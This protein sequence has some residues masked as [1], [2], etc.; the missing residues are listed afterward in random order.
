MESAPKV[1]RPQGLTPLKEIDLRSLADAGDDRDTFLTIY[2][3]TYTSTN[4]RDARPIVAARLR[5]IEK[6]LPRDL[7]DAFLTTREMIDPILTEP[8]VKGEKGRMIFASALQGFLETYRVSVE[9]EPLVVW[10]SSPFLLPLSRLKGDYEDYGLLLLDSQEAR[11]FLISSGAMEEID[12]AKID[13]MNKH[14]KG[15]WSQ[16]RYNRLRKGAIKSF[17]SELIDDLQD[18]E[19]MLRV[20]GLVVAGP[21]EAKSQFMEMLPSALRTKVLGPIDLHMETPAGDL[22]NLG[23]E[24][25]RSG[26]KADSRA[27]AE[28]LKEAVLKDEPAVYGLAD[29]KKALEDGR[30]NFLL[31]SEGFAL[32]GMIC[33]SCHHVHKEGE[34]CPTCGG[35][36]AALKLEELY[37]MAERTGAE[38][39]LVEDDEFLESI[40]HVGAMLRY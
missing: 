35:E 6:A 20:R 25:S 26:I 36:M 37:E 31:I 30:V 13:L 9:L 3:T 12:K 40:G 15:G 24:I 10:D 27:L 17:F 2:F 21:G 33:M 16:M 32:P 23:E 14:K 29:V 28:R 5:A 39:V 22:Q 11:L 34:K 4:T 1:K 18:N 8:P 38:V 19:D 7:K